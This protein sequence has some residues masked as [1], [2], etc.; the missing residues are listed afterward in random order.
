MS[1][2]K[3][4]SNA[5]SEVHKI[6]NS[7]E[8]NYTFKGY[9]TQVFSFGTAGED[10]SGYLIQ[11]KNTKNNLSS[12]LKKTLFCEVCTSL[13]LTVKGNDLMIEV[14]DGKWL[15]KAIAI[16]T[17]TFIVLWPLAVLGTISCLRQKKLH[18][19]LFQDAETLALY[20]NK[21]A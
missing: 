12:V 2:K 21:V 6:A 3:T 10:N 9:N 15:D 7:I 1:F 13:K 8:W 20:N 17:G 14:G 4:I 18:K 5:G 19:T 11:I 16:A